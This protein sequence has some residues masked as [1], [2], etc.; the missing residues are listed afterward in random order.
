VAQRG[1]E[2][3]GLSAEE[4]RFILYENAQRMFGL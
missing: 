4:K 3:L 2:Q 1:L